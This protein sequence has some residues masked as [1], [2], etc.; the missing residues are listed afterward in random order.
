[1]TMRHLAV[2][3]CFLAVAA[4]AISACQVRYVP[5]EPQNKVAA[6]SQNLPGKK[7]KPGKVVNLPPGRG[8]TPPGLMKDAKVTP[9]GHDGPGKANGQNKR[10][11]TPA[12]QNGRSKPGQAVPK[13]LVNKP[14]R[15]TLSVPG[16]PERANTELTKPKAGAPGKS[17]A[18]GKPADVPWNGNR[19]QPQTIETVSEP[20][21]PAKGKPTAL[22]NKP[23]KGDEAD[24]DAT[25]NQAQQSRPNTPGKAH[26]ASKGKQP[27]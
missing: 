12:G 13:G 7:I 23:P 21:P 26:D 14:S 1:M 24:D 17:Q 10:N 8:A 5:A 20:L 15:P 18:K 6:P 11:T 19:P 3:G 27:I 9:P 4:L 25:A 16:Q 22:L 2:N